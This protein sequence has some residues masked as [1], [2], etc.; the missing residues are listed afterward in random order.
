MTPQR[1]AKMKPTTTGK[2]GKGTTETGGKAAGYAAP[3]TPTAYAEKVAKAA[4]AKAAADA[5]L[6]ALADAKAAAKAARDAAKAAAKEAGT[7]SG[8][9]QKAMFIGTEADCN[10][11]ATFLNGL[12]TGFRVEAVINTPGTFAVYKPLDRSVIN[13]R[14]DSSVRFAAYGYGVGI[15]KPDAVAQLMKGR[16]QKVGAAAADTDAE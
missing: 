1:R 11:A 5:A 4:A 2:T 3:M 16:E 13:S 10:A 7:T 6:K 15:G 8:N 9:R 14:D 12:W